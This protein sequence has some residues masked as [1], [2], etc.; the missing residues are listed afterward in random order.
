MANSHLSQYAVESLPGAYYITNFFDATQEE[1]YA[2]FSSA[3]RGSSKRGIT[4]V[5]GP[6]VHAYV[7]DIDDTQEMNYPK[8]ICNMINDMKEKH[9]L[10]EDPIQVSV[11][12]YPP[13]YQMV[14]HKDGGDL[15]E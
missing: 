13:T 7:A 11:N 9:A 10:P 15:R 12:K 5:D 1:Y 2:K 4:R 8:F 14:P 3:V 6:S